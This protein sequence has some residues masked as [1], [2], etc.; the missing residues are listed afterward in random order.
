MH[1]WNIPPNAKHRIRS[2]PGQESGVLQRD[3]TMQKRRLGRTDLEV[4]VMGFGVAFVYHECNAPM[5]GT[6]PWEESTAVLRRAFELGINYFDTSRHYTDCEQR[7]GVALGAVRDQCILATK[8]IARTKKETAACVNES[9]QRLKTDKV[10]LYQLHGVDNHQ[11]LSEVMRRDGA[12]QALKEARAQGKIDFIGITDHRGPVLMD[13]IR[14]GEFDAVTVPFSIVRSQAAEDLIPLARELNVG[15]LIIKPFGGGFIKSSEE[16]VALFGSDLATRAR[17]CLGFVLAHDV[18]SIIPGFVSVEEVEAAA[19]VAGTFKE[20]TP[21]EVEHLQPGASLE[22]F[23]R[24]CGLCLPCPEGLDIER[25]LAMD[26]CVAA[27]GLKEW[28]RSQYQTLPTKVDRCTGCRGCET[29][30]PH[31]L[32]VM[33]MLRRTEANLQVVDG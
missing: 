4:S 5:T 30:C 20:F 8:T 1:F 12:L 33:D 6:V 24:E 27:Y 23:C 28:A 13:A 31:H 11:T 26:R 21:E 25:I 32:P 7:I 14:T 15:V 29:R 16:F 18:S 2:F 22:R 9:L 3:L 19:A 10:D 17:R